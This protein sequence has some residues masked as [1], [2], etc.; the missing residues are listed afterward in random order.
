MRERPALVITCEFEGG[1]EVVLD[2]TVGEDRDRLVD[3]LVG[4][5]VMGELA[6]RWRSFTGSLSPSARDSREEGVL[7][8]ACVEDADHS[9][10]R[11]D[12]A[13]SERRS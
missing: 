10:R 3:W 11:Q 5:H 2:Y 12:D 9:R 7:A 1:I 8:A 13:Q 4:S 6:E